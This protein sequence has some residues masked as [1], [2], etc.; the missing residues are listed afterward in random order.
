MG[1][2]KALLPHPEGGTW[3][4]RTLRLLLE[5]EVPVT[6]LSRHAT[7]LQLASALNAEPITAMAEPS[8]REGPLLALHRLMEMHPNQRLLLCPVDMPW[9]ELEVLRNLLQAAAQHP[10]R[11]QLAHDG[12]HRQPLLGLYPSTTAIR[13]SLAEAVQG[14]ER[15]L[16]SWL[17]AQDCRDVLLKPATLRNINH[18]EDLPTSWGKG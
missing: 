13:T 4:E 6:L 18:P 5:L 10:Q 16:Q 15:R 11:I 8:P 2:D 9:L 17:A 12:K 7:H 1:R 3:L 14:G